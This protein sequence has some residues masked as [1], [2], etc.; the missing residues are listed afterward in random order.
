MAEAKLTGLDL[1]R[2]VYEG[3]VKLEITGGIPTWETFPGSRHQ[4]VM[5]RIRATIR[6]LPQGE[7]QTGCG[8]DHIADVD[9]R[10]PDGSIKRPDIAIFCEE[11]PD[12]DEALPLVPD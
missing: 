11:P 7:R 10:F 8:C 3:R 12:Q 1:E 4:R 9:I 5:D 6:P 2:L